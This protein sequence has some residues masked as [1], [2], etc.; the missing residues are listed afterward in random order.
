M[1]KPVTTRP[2]NKGSNQCYRKICEVCDHTNILPIFP[3]RFALGE[4]GEKLK[5]LEYPTFTELYKNGGK[6]ANGMVTRL[7]RSGWVFIFTEKKA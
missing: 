4:Y 1:N 3:V 5:N 2:E 7:L 6:A